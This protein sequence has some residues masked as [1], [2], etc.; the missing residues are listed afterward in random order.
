MAVAALITFHICFLSFLF[1]F[2]TSASRLLSNTNCMSASECSSGFDRQKIRSITTMLPAECHGSLCCKVV[3]GRL[4]FN[5][6]A[7]F[8]FT[9]ALITSP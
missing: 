5:A 3:S 4:R 8:L 6:V 9:L 1:F 7:V 2:S